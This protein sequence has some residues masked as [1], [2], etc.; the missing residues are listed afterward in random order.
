MG[1]E[2]LA[3]PIIYRPRIVE[4]LRYGTAVLGIA[5]NQTLGDDS[6]VVMAF[7]PAST[8]RN[9]TMETAVEGLAHIIANVSTGTG[10]LTIKNPAAATIGSV[11]PGDAAIVM[12]IN[13]AWACF[14]LDSNLATG[15]EGF[16][17]ATPI[18]QPA[19][20]DQG[21][22]TDSSGGTKGITTAV[23]AAAFQQNIS[24]PVQLAD[25]AN[26]QVW[27]AKVPFAFTLLSAGFRTGKPAS[28]AAKAATLTA[29]VGGQA[30]LTGGVIGLT[31]AN[32]NVTGTL[33]AASAI[34][35]ATAT[36]TAGMDL[37][38]T[39]SAVTTFVEGD[40]YIEAIV[41]NNDLANVTA[42]EIAQL[43]AFRT[44]LVNLG[45]IKGAA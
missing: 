44:A 5:A 43:T 24:I 33:T 32:Q 12:T 40:G 41:S 34:S 15:Y 27:K 21:A 8:G 6:P 17:G 39:A 30:A 18:V 20:A 23:V 11:G 1:R 31:T 36:G 16:F 22:I 19:S 38:W 25:L 4:G 35:G 29:T 7:D 2:N 9:I 13:G 3:D 45:L 14:T 10:V 28:T 26:A 42:T 37:E